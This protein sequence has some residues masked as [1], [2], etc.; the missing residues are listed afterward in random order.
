MSKNSLSSAAPYGVRAIPTVY[1]GRQYRSRLEAKWAA[2]FDL[3]GMRAEYEPM[4][5]GTWSPDFLLGTSTLVEVKPIQTFDDATADKMTAACEA[6]GAFVDGQSFEDGHALLLASSPWVEDHNIR[7][8][9]A[10]YKSGAEWKWA[11]CFLV[12]TVGWER[13]GLKADIVIHS[14]GGIGEAMSVPLVGED[15][16]EYKYLCRNYKKHAL[17]LWAKATNAVQ[18]RPPA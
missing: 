3:L 11:D 17:E 4:D 8:G 14:E 10:A 16:P 5:L 2:F 7:V 18:W 13:P 9:W 1:K 15:G 12:W 6:S